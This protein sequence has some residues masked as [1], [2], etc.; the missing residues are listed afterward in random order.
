MQNQSKWHPS[1]CAFIMSFLFPSVMSAPTW[2][3]VVKK[4]A[5]HTIKAGCN[6][7]QV[8]ILEVK[9]KYYEVRDGAHSI[10]SV[11]ELDYNEMQLAILELS[12]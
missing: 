1:Q 11:M 9:G 5:Q 4:F 7:G 8:L 3:R 10:Y 2:S 6:A 12:E